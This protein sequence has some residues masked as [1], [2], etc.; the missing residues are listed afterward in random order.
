MYKFYINKNSYFYPFDSKNLYEE[1]IH[2]LKKLQKI[3]LKLPEALKTSELHQFHIELGHK[4][5]DKQE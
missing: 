5:A 4:Q 2:T 3:R 1:I